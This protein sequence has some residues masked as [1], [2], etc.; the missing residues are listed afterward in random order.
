MV[1]TISLTG[2]NGSI[3]YTANPTE[4]EN[5]PPFKFF[6]NFPTKQYATIRL[7]KKNQANALDITTFTQIQAGEPQHFINHKDSTELILTN[8]KLNEFTVY[9]RGLT[10]LSR[11]AELTTFFKQ[12]AYEGASN[13]SYFIY[14]FRGEG[15][16]F[17]MTLFDQPHFIRL[18]FRQLSNRN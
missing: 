11:K 17:K 9:L 4:I 6:A 8:G 15:Y 13:G 16:H 3:D 2:C 18:F 5:E 10:Y 12:Q 7:G 14:N 1:L